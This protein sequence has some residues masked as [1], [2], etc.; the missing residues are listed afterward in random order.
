M[1][2]YRS[3]NVN[4]S[5]CSVMREYWSVN[6]NFSFCNVKFERRVVSLLPL[7][8]T[9]WRRHHYCTSKS[10]CNLREI[11]VPCLGSFQSLSL[12]FTALLWPFTFSCRRAITLYHNCL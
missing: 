12:G 1:R 7:S 5:F 3:I 11:S 9:F 8:S 2:E 6:D 4:F 10:P